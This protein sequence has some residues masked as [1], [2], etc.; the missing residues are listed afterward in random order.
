MNSMLATAWNYSKAK[1]KE[2]TIV[3]FDT[4]SLKGGVNSSYAYWRWT[5]VLNNR[6]AR[7]HNYDFVYIH[8]DSY[9]AST[10]ESEGVDLD[11]DGIHSIYKTR[12]QYVLYMPSKNL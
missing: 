2:T 4:Q 10:S 8:A 11:N 7:R 6:Y 12:P 5:A 9:N 3:I 1:P